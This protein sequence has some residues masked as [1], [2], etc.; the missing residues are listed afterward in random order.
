MA[1]P[2]ADLVFISSVQGRGYKWLRSVENLEY[3]TGWD[4]PGNDRILANGF[5]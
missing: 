1:K 4:T 2:S 3:L 5:L